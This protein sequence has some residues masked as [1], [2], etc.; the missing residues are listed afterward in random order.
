M[1]QN[2]QNRNHTTEMI[3]SST[4][5]SLYSNEFLG[6]KQ[7]LRQKT[8]SIL[9]L[10][11]DFWVEFEA[12]FVLENFFDLINNYQMIENCYHPF[13]AVFNRFSPKCIAWNVS[14]PWY[15]WVGSLDHQSPEGRHALNLPKRRRNESADEVSPTN[16]EKIKK[17][18]AKNVT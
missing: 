17:L 11:L 5:I 18:W 1:E 7:K 15:D 9:K 16:R 12:I 13:L 10:L 6:I 4:N 14:S 2:G 3:E 8:I